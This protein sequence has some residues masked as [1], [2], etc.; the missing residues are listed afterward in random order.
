MAYSDAPFKPAG[1]EGYAFGDARR[2]V[3]DNFTVIGRGR[4]DDAG[5]DAEE[6]DPVHVSARLLFVI[7]DKSCHGFPLYAFQSG[8]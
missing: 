7:Y 8:R 6:V 3:K 4:L 2:T 1:W 5:E